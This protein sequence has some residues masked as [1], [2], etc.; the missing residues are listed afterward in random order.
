MEC[1]DKKMSGVFEKKE[2]NFS[3]ARILIRAR[4]DVITLAAIDYSA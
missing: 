1:P 2:K 3:Q 4:R